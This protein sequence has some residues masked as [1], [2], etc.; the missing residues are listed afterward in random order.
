MF[1]FRNKNKNCSV[2][3]QN[4]LNCDSCNKF[5]HQAECLCVELTY[6]TCAVCTVNCGIH[7]PEY[8]HVHMMLMDIKVNCTLQSN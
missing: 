3:L 7:T 8:Y 5:R 1:Y 4:L 2:D 6:V